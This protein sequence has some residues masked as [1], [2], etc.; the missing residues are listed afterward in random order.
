MS[1]IPT[2]SPAPNRP[3]AEAAAVALTVGGVA[4]AFGAAACCGLPFLLATAGVGTAWLGGIALAASPHRVFLLIA[5]AVC[6]A[7][8]ATLLSRQRTGLACGPKSVFSRP[9][10]RGLTMVGLLLG[11]VLLYLG[12]AYA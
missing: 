7:F 10:I 3:A 1:H 11:A 4:A 12:Y 2:D 5:A 9:A 6:L 8:G